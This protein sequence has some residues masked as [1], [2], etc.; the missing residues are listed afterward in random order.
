MWDLNKIANVQCVKVKKYNIDIN[1]NKKIKKCEIIFLTWTF[2]IQENYADFEKY[3]SFFIKIFL[4]LFKFIT[5][6]EITLL[7]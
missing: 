2:L 7:I 4:W 1:N 5:E 6:I 3:N